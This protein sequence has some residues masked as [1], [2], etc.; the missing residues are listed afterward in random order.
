MYF[1]NV[2]NYIVTSKHHK[3]GLAVSPENVSASSV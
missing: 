2:I 3:L 1:T